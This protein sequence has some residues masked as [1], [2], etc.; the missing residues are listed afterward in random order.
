MSNE[1]EFTTTE[2]DLASKLHDLEDALNN[3]QYQKE[4]FEAVARY[5]QL[6]AEQRA[7]DLALLRFNIRQEAKQRTLAKR[8]RERFL[9]VVLVYLCHM[10]EVRAL[11]LCAFA[12][13]QP[14]LADS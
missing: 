8:D 4:V 7:R 13:C 5:K 2:L 6:T 10:S 1:K 14:A 12:D 11:M 3:E 9:Y